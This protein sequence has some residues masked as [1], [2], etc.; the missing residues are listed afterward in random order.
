MSIE[1]ESDDIE[2]LKRENAELRENLVRAKRAAEIYRET[3]HFWK[4][5]DYFPPTVHRRGTGR[6]TSR[7]AWTFSDRNRRRVRTEVFAEPE[8]TATLLFHNR[9][10]PPSDCTLFSKPCMIE[11]NSPSAHNPFAGSSKNSRG[12]RWNSASRVLTS[13]ISICSSGSHSLVLLLWNSQ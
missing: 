2:S 13:Q 9:R 6:H 5:A 10:A 12:R 4:K 7:A 8:M 11:E 3:T 1:P